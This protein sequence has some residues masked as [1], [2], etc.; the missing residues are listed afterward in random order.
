MALRSW[1]PSKAGQLAMYDPRQK[2][3]P[4][5][6]N[7]R[8]ELRG[9]LALRSSIAPPWHGCLSSVHLLTRYTGLNPRQIGDRS[10]FPLNELV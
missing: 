8:S 1:D 7:K 6:D 2:R 3:N 4:Y 9:T 5:T 10:A